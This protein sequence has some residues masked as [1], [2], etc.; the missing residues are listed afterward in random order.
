MNESD[1]KGKI[2]KADADIILAFG[3]RMETM[4]ARFG[5]DYLCSQA[6]TVQRIARVALYEANYE[7]RRQRIIHFHDEEEYPYTLEEENSEPSGPVV[8]F[9]ARISDE[10]E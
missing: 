9:M 4:C 10:C 6:Q 1:P 3:S 5:Y 7:M 2:S 8:R